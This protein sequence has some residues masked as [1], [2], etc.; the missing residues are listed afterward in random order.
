MEY[1]RISSMRLNNAKDFQTCSVNDI[2]HTFQER[3]KLVVRTHTMNV[4]KSTQKAD[5]GG[6]LLICE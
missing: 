1:T 4:P 2:I 3:D 5:R 6:K